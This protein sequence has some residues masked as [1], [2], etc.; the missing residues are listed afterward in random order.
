MPT[1]GPVGTA[2]VTSGGLAALGDGDI[3]S[4]A[5][6]AA[7]AAGIVPPGEVFVPAAAAMDLCGTRTDAGPCRSFRAGGARNYR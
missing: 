7:G 4:N 2:I 3:W 5:H 1:T 6:C